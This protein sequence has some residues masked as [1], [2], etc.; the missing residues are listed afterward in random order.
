MD[1]RASRCD[2]LRTEH[3]CNI[4]PKHKQRGTFSLTLG[5]QAGRWLCSS[6]CQCHE[7]DRGTLWKCY[8]LQEALKI[9]L[10]KAMPDLDWIL[11]FREKHATKEYYWDNWQN[12]VRNYRL[13]YCTDSLKLVT[14]L[15]L[16]RASQAPAVKSAC[17][18]RST[19]LICG[20]R[21]SSRGEMAT[22]ASYCARIIPQTEKH[23]SCSP[24]GIAKGWTG[25]SM[26]ALA[27][28]EP[29]PILRKYTLECRKV[30]GQDGHNLL[31]TDQEQNYIFLQIHIEWEQVIQKVINKKPSNFHEYIHRH[32][33]VRLYNV[34]NSLS[35]H[36][37]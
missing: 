18:C 22:C 16:S 2:I 3:L 36:R 33:K 34:S 35:P 20:L 10:L 6:K 11:Y 32:C 4:Q 1:T 27:I 8:K 14:V 7:E 12:W 19:G 23:G 25:L 17:Q 26:H 31:S 15:W 24:C 30:K 37:L 21:R 29:I 5:G 28:W 9:W 13:K